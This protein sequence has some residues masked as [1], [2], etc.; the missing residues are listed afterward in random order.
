MLHQK[1]E[2]FR[3]SDMKEELLRSISRCEL[4]N[5]L[6]PWYDENRNCQ[7]LLCISIHRLLCQCGECSERRGLD[8]AAPPAAAP[9]SCEHLAAAAAA[10]AAVAAPGEHAA[11]TARERAASAAATTTSATRPAAAGER[12]ATV[13]AT[14][15]LPL[16]LTNLG[17]TCFVNAILQCLLKAPGLEKFLNLQYSEKALAFAAPFRGLYIAIQKNTV[18]RSKLKDMIIFARC[19]LMLESI[20]IEK[21]YIQHDA[22][23]FLL[24]LIQ[25]F[26]ENI[27]QLP[28]QTDPDAGE[29]F[30]EWK[31]L[32]HFREC[33][34]LKCLHCRVQSFQYVDINM[35]VLPITA[36]SLIGCFKSYCS[37]EKL[38]QFNCRNTCP[39]GSVSVTHS[40]QSTPLNLIVILAR[41]EQLNG[42]EYIKNNSF[43]KFEEVLDLAVHPE[44][45]DGQHNPKYQ[46][47]A[48]VE[49]LG[50][51]LDLG[52]YIAYVK[53][54]SQ[55]VGIDDDKIFNIDFQVL[56]RKTQYILFYQLDMSNNSHSQ[57]AGEGSGGGGV[58]A[59]VM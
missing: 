51:S 19:V 17:N 5:H 46:L 39:S 33:I 29:F 18:T 22:Q 20:P 4:V 36:D 14:G 30:R 35:L 49:H 21:P 34:E 1:F 37:S 53:F 57:V 23:E 44:H 45:S 41:F 55:W 15:R 38:Q 59:Q 24:N 3:T 12:A 42:R 11:A 9:A 6:F 26:H 48:V 7:C 25:L 56:Q 54:N 13:A 47:Y 40:I 27:Q 10:A 31:Q 2:P 28:I 16:G 58:G 8:P 52:H 43:V 32:F 50:L